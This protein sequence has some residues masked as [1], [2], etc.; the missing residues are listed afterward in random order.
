MI[1]YA[2]G[3]IYDDI[4]KEDLAAGTVIVADEDIE[5][6]SGA[7]AGILGPSSLSCRGLLPLSN[8]TSCNTTGEAL[9][10]K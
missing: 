9:N 2:P 10:V 7:S 1:L 3:S 5:P 4:V 8:S 6:Y